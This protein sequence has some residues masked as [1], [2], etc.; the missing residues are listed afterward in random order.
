RWAMEQGAELVCADRDSDGYGGHRDAVPDPWA[1]EKLA[2]E[3]YDE[4]CRA[5]LGPPD[6]EDARREETMA[7]HVSRLLDARKR[8][9]LVFAARK[10]RGKKAAPAAPK[11]VAA[12]EKEPEPE[13]YQ[14]AV[15]LARTAKQRLL[16]EDGERIATAALSVLMRVARNWSL[17]A[18]GLAPDLVQ[19][20]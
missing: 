7:F 8:G 17:L 19:L 18:G 13:R 15:R 1:L 14:L 10:K 11:R 3:K 12:T 20:V 6:E 16:D 2:P 9:A 5:A 4:L